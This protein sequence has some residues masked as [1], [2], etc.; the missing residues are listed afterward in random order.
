MNE[1]LKID[2]YIKALTYLK[3][4]INNF[5]YEVFTDDYKWTS[6]QKIFQD[7]LKIHS[8]DNTVSNTISMFVEMLNF[9]NFIVG[10]STFSLIPA[11]LKESNNSKIIIANPWFRNKDRNLNFRNN[12]IRLKNQY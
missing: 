7:S 9:E 6:K 4:N 5:S 3:K 1:E 12:W 11:L 2:F 8:D 10:N